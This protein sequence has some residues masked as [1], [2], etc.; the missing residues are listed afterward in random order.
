MALDERTLEDA[1]RQLSA[2]ERAE[3]PIYELT[4]GTS[5][6]DLKSFIRSKLGIQNIEDLDVTIGR[7]TGMEIFRILVVRKRKE[8]PTPPPPDGGQP[9]PKAA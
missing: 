6:Q 2:T 3:I 7:A 5:L 8:S 1:T 9:M 4:W